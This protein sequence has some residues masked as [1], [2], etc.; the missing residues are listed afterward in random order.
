MNPSELRGIARHYF[1]PI[2]TMELIHFEC[3]AKDNV[4]R[5]I[6]LAINKLENKI[7]SCHYK[8]PKDDPWTPYFS[9]V[10]EKLPGMSMALAGAINWEFIE[11]E[12]GQA[13]PLNTH[14]AAV[15]KVFAA[16][17][18]NLELPIYFLPGMLILKA[19]EQYYGLGT[20]LTRQHEKLICRCFGVYRHTI[21]KYFKKNPA[22]TISIV[23]GDLMAG[24]G[25]GSCRDDIEIIGAEFCADPIGV[26]INGHRHIGPVM[27]IGIYTPIECAKIVHHYLEQAWPGS[28]L[29]RASGKRIEIAAPGAVY[30]MMLNDWDNIAETINQEL[31]G[32]AFILLHLQR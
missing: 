1:F 25:C 32:Q 21:E 16:K 7:T 6:F 17:L 20:V 9:F 8:V 2:E 23:S 15:G 28:E 4:G 26:H 30:E 14:E 3:F 31:A 11:N 10:C 22:A 12:F 5:K 13:S 19:L 27:G 24:A 29:I 18:A